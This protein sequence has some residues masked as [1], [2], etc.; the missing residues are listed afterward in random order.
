MV[1]NSDL[2]FDGKQFISSSRA[3][4]I[5][6]YVNDYIGQLCRDGK[7]DCRMVGR[8]WY[9]S[10]E[11]LISHKNANGSASKNRSKKSIE[12]L[13]PNLTLEAPQIATLDVLPT[14]S[15][16]STPVVLE[17]KIEVPVAPSVAPEILR[18]VFTP[19]QVPQISYPVFAEISEKTIS[20]PVHVFEESTVEE[21][22]E[23][24]V[25]EK[26]VP[27]ISHISFPDF[28][29]QKNIFVADTVSPNL[30]TQKIFDTDVEKI[31]S[32]TS[33]PIVSPFFVH[34]FPTAFALMVSFIFAFAGF[35][36]AV[37]ANPTAQVAYNNAFNSS[38]S[39]SVNSET[40]SL[41]LQANVF[42]G[43]RGT[44]DQ[45]GL[46][47]YHTINNFLFDTRE[48]IL[49][50][51]GLEVEKKVSVV[52]QQTDTEPTSPTQ[53]M[54]V[55]PVDEKTNRDATVAKIKDSF[56]DEV[57]VKPATDNASGVITPVFKKAKGDDYL[58]VLVPIKN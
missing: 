35:L 21:K 19:V 34:A 36:F 48:R 17:T 32:V 58:Y 26:S 18:E 2:Y 28:S 57:S 31:S 16:I 24:V 9:V 5:S 11:S 38:P 1:M 29:E 54:V 14:V 4:K 49:V 45:A 30:S 47:V 3:A 37:R 40:F 42:S 51:S 10:F 13:A 46:A 20:I 27:V 7:L 22:E 12:I 41:N 23:S 25:L 52:Q 6:G 43:F 55:V 50:M 56:S 39:S 53:G 15:A 33:R 8:T 44:V